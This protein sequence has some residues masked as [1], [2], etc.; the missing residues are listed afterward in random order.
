MDNEPSPKPVP[1][2][3]ND[4]EK[5]SARRPSGSSR[6]S[7]TDATVTSGPV[8]NP[9]PAAPVGSPGQ[10]R[11]AATI[12]PAHHETGQEHHGLPRA[13]FRRI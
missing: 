1:R 9:V 5:P 2:T 7:R 11:F 13:P 12:D 6:C 10:P 3:A 4:G 8:H